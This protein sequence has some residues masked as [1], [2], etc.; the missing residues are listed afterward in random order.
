MSDGG[1]AGAAGQLPLEQG[2]L[3]AWSGRPRQGLRLQVLDTVLV[4]FGLFWLGLGVYLVIHSQSV[5]RLENVLVECG[6]A[7]VFLGY[8]L[9][10][11]VLRFL[12]D[13]ARRGRTSYAVTNRRLVILEGR[14]LETIPL[15]E[16]P[17]ISVQEH[18]DGRGTLWFGRLPGWARSPDGSYLGFQKP[19]GFERPIPRFDSVEEPRRVR[20]LIVMYAAASGGER[21][22]RE[23][24]RT[25]M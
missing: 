4:P 9:F 15:T 6:F 23:A 21:K 13:A 5:E 16:M 11:L 25:R 19:P 8:A 18:R 10:L 17:S 22:N 20:D 3:V 24:D 14:H 1:R 7:V 2:E 12:M